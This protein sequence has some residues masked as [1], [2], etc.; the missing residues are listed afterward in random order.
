MF[1]IFQGVSLEIL[2][3]GSIPEVGHWQRAS[4]ELRMGTGKLYGLSLNGMNE[5][6]I[7]IENNKWF[8]L[9]NDERG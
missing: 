2:I 5:T 3:L 9:W 1:L 7:A 8:S 4:C 6:M